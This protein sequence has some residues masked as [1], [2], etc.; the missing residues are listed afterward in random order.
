LPILSTPSALF[1]AGYVA[2]VV[3][4]RGVPSYIVSTPTPANPGN[5]GGPV[6]DKYGR[7]VALIEKHAAPSDS[8]DVSNYLPYLYATNLTGCNPEDKSQ[9][10]PGAN[11]VPGN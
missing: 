2:A 6:V 10:G 8:T 3:N 11:S 1:G 9:W 4:E 5:S 7:L